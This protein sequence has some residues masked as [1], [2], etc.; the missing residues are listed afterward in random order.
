MSFNQQSKMHRIIG[1]LVLVASILFY[2][3]LKKS[4]DDVSTAMDISQKVLLKPNLLCFS[5]GG[6][7]A[8]SVH[9]AITHG[10]IAALKDKMSLQPAQISGNEKDV[11][12]L[13]N[14]GLAF[15]NSQAIIAGN[16]G[17]SWAMS[18]MCYSK[19]YL[20]I[21]NGNMG[22]LESSLPSECFGNPISGSKD[23]W[24][25][26]LGDTN[27][28]SCGS[29]EC[30]CPSGFRYDS[31]GG[32]FDYCKKCNIPVQEKFDVG[33]YFRTV[34]NAVEAY[35]EQHGNSLT[36]G[37]IDILPGS[38]NNYIK[39]FLFFLEAPWTTAVKDIVFDSAG[40][41]GEMLISEN[42]N[43]T[44]SQIVWGVS[45][46]R[47]AIVTGQATGDITRGANIFYAINDPDCSRKIQGKNDIVAST[48]QCGIA[49]PL[50][51]DYDFNEQRS[52]LPIFSGSAS[53]T[54]LLY[55]NEDD[56][57]PYAN[58]S[59]DLTQKT[60]IGKVYELAASSGAALAALCNTNT[61][62]SAVNSWLNDHHVKW[63]ASGIADRA[64]T[65]ISAWLDNSAVPLKFENG[66]ASFY[67][68]GKVP[69]DL[70]PGAFNQ[71]PVVRLGDGGYYDN[72]AVAFAIRAWQE[73]NQTMCRVVAINAPEASTVEFSKGNNTSDAIRYLFGCNTAT[74][75]PV[76]QA[77]FD[78]VG[79]TSIEYD[80][81]NPK[82][83]PDADFTAGKAI[84]WGQTSYSSPGMDA[85]LTVSISV[86]VYNTQTIE[87]PSL[88]IKKGLP[89][90]MI[91]FDVS[92]SVPIF[93]MPGN[94][95]QTTTESYVSTVKAI[96]NLVQKIPQ[97]YLNEIFVEGAAS[98][99]K[100]PDNADVFSDVVGVS[101]FT[102]Y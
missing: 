77:S 45:M 94:N 24:T 34:S 71:T 57:S 102:P 98:F 3:N 23:W 79:N 51:F 95:N 97:N 81:K 78:Q 54:N 52:T 60:P 12:G 36:E 8:L 76:S 66:K 42:P 63:I 50:V 15:L 10:I 5:G 67:G 27:L 28:D 38:E 68:D 73:R 29:S 72:S 4:S 47:D 58:I 43:G 65:F 92:T 91:V 17:G 7:R 87:N 96:S 56:N 46:M 20:S 48:K 31:N 37:I 40:D 30:C 21:L 93:I 69:N 84:W 59:V 101:T 25:C 53:P 32:P 88:G 61:L 35:R 19:N 22:Q 6:L 18:L 33:K 89:V 41:V 75:C 83:F 16:S 90:E 70:N 55:F 14:Y 80:M 64:T 26:G 49:L 39:P 99:K 11:L 100:S 85:Q 9:T 2:L 44:V 86:N 74:A 82:I 1:V 62:I 13:D